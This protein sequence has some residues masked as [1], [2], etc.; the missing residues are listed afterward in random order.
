MDTNC[1]PILVDF[2]FYSYKADFIQGLLKKHENK[3]VRS[4]YF[5][6]CYTGDDLSL[7]KFGDLVDHIYPI[8]L[9]IK[10][11]QIQLGLL[12]TMTYTLKN[13]V[14]AGQERNYEKRNYS[15]FPIV[16]FAF[17]C[18]NIP[19]APVYMVYISQWI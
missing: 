8:D 11:T 14:N 7:Y 12:H 17:I 19:A 13:T 15:Y 16:N 3:L 6:L 18:N 2:Y 10:D 5:T 1:V 9:E 4:F